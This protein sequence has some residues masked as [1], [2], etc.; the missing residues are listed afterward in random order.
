MLKG[1]AKDGEEEIVGDKNETSLGDEL[2]L[3]KI[4]RQL[5]RL[6]NKLLKGLETCDEGSF[7]LK[8]SNSG[9]FLATAVL[10]GDIYTIN[11][12]LVSMYFEI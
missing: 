9:S 6:P 12:Y 10:V 11:V 7:T 5:C 2:D 3:S 1:D 4:K 8:F